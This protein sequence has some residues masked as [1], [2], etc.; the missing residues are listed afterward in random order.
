MFGIKARSF[1]TIML[2]I[3]VTALLLRIAIEEIIKFSIEQ[4][5][6]SAQIN[7]KLISTALE[8]YAKNNSN[9]FPENFTP[10]TQGASRYLDKDYITLSPVKGYIYSCSKLE[11]SGYTCVAAPAKCGLTGKMSYTVSTGGLFVSENCEK[12]E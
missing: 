9:S 6:S 11:L 1:V 8:N 3:A 2:V 10:L 7:L 5:D 12:K 4:N